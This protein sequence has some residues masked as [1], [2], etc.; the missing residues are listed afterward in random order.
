MKRKRK[1]GFSAEN[2]D[3][4]DEEEVYKPVVR[5]GRDRQQGSARQQRRTVKKKKFSESSESEDEEVIGA[6][7]SD[8]NGVSKTKGLSIKY[9][10][11]NVRPQTSYKILYGLIDTIDRVNTRQ[12]VQ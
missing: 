11:I 9:V 6:K 3:F 12:R 10:N 7:R 2:S 4:S 8:N 1:N 5:N